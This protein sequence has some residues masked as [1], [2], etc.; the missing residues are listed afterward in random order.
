MHV[1]ARCSRNASISSLEVRGEAVAIGASSRV[2]WY[3]RDG[4]PNDV[5]VESGD[6]SHLEASPDGRVLAVAVSTRDGTSDI[7][8]KDLATVR[9]SV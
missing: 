9:S 3:L 5:V 2:R 1:R 4:T 7:W 6:Y 8:L